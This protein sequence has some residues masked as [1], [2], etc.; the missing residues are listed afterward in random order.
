MIRAAAA[1]HG[2]SLSGVHIHEVIRSERM[3]DPEEQYTIFHPSEVELSTTTQELI[4]AHT[5]ASKLS[6]SRSKNCR[7]SC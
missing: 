7:G 6:T 2:W 5:V 3:L 4:A 1:S